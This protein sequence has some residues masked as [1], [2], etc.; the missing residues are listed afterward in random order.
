MPAPSR[1]LQ[2]N[3]FPQAARLIDLGA[4]LLRWNKIWTKDI[5]VDGTATVP[6]PVNTTDAT[7]KAYVDAL[8]NPVVATI[9]EADG[10]P[11]ISPPSTLRFDQADGFV[12]TNP[13]GTIAR[14]DLA[15]VPNSVL[16]NSTVTVN[17]TSIALGASGT[18]TLASANFANQ[19]TTTTVLHGNAAGNPSFAQ[20]S[21]TDDVTGTLPVGNGGTNATTAAT[22]RTSLGAA[23]LDP[24]F[25]T[26][27]TNAE[28]SNERVLTAGKGISFTDAGAGSTLTLNSSFG[29]S[30]VRGV[31]GARASTTTYTIS[32]ARLIE[33]F[34]PTTV[35]IEKVTVSQGS[36]TVDITTQGRNGLDYA[37]G[38]TASTWHYLYYTWDGSTVALRLSKTSP[39]TGP[40]L[41]N[42]ETS[43]A[44]I[45][46]LFLNG[47]SQFIATRI[48]GNFV[49]Y[50]ARQSVL[51]GGTQTGTYTSIGSL[52]SLVP[53]EATCG[54]IALQCNAS[55]TG[56][57]AV[58]ISISVDATNAWCDVQG[59]NSNTTAIGYMQTPNSAQTLYYMMTGAAT[60][61][62]SVFVIGYWVDNGS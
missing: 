27:A 3:L 52:A 17:G 57:G 20:V 45:T 47:S 22:A 10:S 13:S 56:T 53:P 34:N 28:L 49:N 43:W 11:S 62:G 8:F 41:A 18:L 37:P 32:S 4:S 24:Q 2:E 7:T 26:L 1:F 58:A 44:F 19:G 55:T 36:L 9:E 31:V 14:V 40:T 38:A 15:S 16:A 21:L 59:Y 61:S 6:T 25:L 42:G 12:L 51:S 54:Q 39:A 5:D 29:I 60:A 30:A 50:D 23:P 35:V 33:F 46:A 48:R